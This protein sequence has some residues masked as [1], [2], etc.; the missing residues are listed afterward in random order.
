MASVWLHFTEITTEA[1]VRLK[2]KEQRACIIDSKT[3]TA[4]KTM[5]Y[6]QGM[7]KRHV[8]QNGH[9]CLASC[10]LTEAVLP[11]KPIL[12]NRVQRVI[13]LL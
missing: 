10:Y 8:K 3:K 9:K 11:G 5:I 4:G 13:V 1:Y 6:H 12:T 2:Y 7:I